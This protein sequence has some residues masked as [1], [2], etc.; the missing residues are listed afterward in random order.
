MTCFARLFKSTTKYL[1]DILQA[2]VHVMTTLYPFLI[3]RD[4]QTTVITDNVLSAIVDFMSD[5]IDRPVGRAAMD[6]YFRSANGRNL[7]QLMLSVSSP[8]I[9]KVYDDFS[10]EI[11]DSSNIIFIFELQDHA[12]KVIAFVNKV[13]ATLEKNPED[14]TC[15]R[16][17]ASAVE[18]TDCAY[19]ELYVWLEFLVLGKS[20]LLENMLFSLH[21]HGNIQTSVKN[22]ST[23][24]KTKLL[25]IFIIYLQM[26]DLKKSCNC[27]NCNF[28]YVSIVFIA[29]SD[30]LC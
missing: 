24:L 11:L 19:P 23:P 7:A 3:D 29:F 20:E 27:R 17:A 28:Y 12:L 10:R 15:R 5:V 22:H 9:S 18:L 14:Q 13:F 30:C 4:Q 6:K 25:K 16:L 1:L 2:Y 21:L 26:P 8:K